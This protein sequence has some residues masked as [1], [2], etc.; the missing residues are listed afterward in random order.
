MIVELIAAVTVLSIA[1]LALSAVYEAAIFSVHSAGKRS[2]AAQLAN[3][4][5]ELYGALPPSS[6]SLIGLDS[7]SLTSAQ[8]SDA[9][10]SSDE[11]ALAGAA[12][13][14]VTIAS[15][16]SSARCLP[17]QVKTGDDKHSY[18]VETF[19]RDVTLS[20]QTERI[21]SVVVRDNASGSQVVT[22]SAGFD[23]GPRS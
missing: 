1:V 13:T 15:C 19:I 18:R 2:S 16:G 17:V 5:L 22:F 7:T 4:Q 14:D 12:G 8:T 23:A 9:Y 11:A 21:V 10:Y 20:G 6:F 3:D